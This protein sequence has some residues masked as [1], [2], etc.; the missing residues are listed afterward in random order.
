MPRLG[1]LIVGAAALAALAACDDTTSTAVSSAAPGNSAEAAARQACVRDVRSTTGNPD[2]SVLSSSF[3]EAGTEVILQVG[4]TGQWS[5]IA[6]GD[7][8]TADIMSLTDE[9]AL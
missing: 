1:K 9:G 2:V 7:G 8:T 6:Y 4:P 3:S 5:C